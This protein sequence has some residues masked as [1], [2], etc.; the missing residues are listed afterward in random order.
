MARSSGRPKLLL[1]ELP[2]GLAAIQGLLATEKIRTL[3]RHAA[4]A[5]PL[6]Q[7]IE[8]G[9]N[10][11]HA[12]RVKLRVPQMLFYDSYFPR[13]EPDVLLTSRI[14]APRNVSEV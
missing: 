5:Q 7:V 6:A 2:H 8:S 10:I 11:S 3:W 9:T 1:H 13:R 12:L 14:T 4:A